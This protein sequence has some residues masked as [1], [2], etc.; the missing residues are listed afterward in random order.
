MVATNCLGFAL[1]SSKPD[2][3]ALFESLLPASA[4]LVLVAGGASIDRFESSV[5]TLPATSTGR[6]VGF[7]IDLTV[8]AGTG[9]AGSFER[10]AIKFWS[11]GVSASCGGGSGVGD[12]YP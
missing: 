10:L 5:T 11:P 6:V 7:S 8:A 12:I 1:K 2:S 9:I 4:P 3:M